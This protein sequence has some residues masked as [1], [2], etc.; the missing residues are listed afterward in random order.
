MMNFKTQNGSPLAGLAAASFKA[1]AASAALLSLTAC[2]TLEENTKIT[3]WTLVDPVQRHPI[4]V[5]QQPSKLVLKVARGSYGLDPE[6]RARLYNFANEYRANY[7]G[8]SKLVIH[9]P[10][11]GP[12]EVSAM[13]AVAEI[14]HL[15][16]EGGFDE[17]LVSIEAYSDESDPQPPVRV[18]Y[19]RYVAEGPECGNWPTNLAVQTDGL[20]QANFGCNQQKNLAAMVVNP[21]DLLG[22]RGS[23]PRYGGRR[24]AVWDKFRKGETTGAQK[25]QDEKV[26]V[27]GAE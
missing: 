10:S 9:A 21:A 22:P 25:S 19:Q 12:N 11:G 17:T 24:D 1:L 3:G 18:S 16:R 14:R 2:K 27:K 13:Q 6:Q 15:L 7:S 8:N 4:T 5:S 20:N 26:R 23:T